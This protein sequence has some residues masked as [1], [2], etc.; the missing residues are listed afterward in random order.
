MTNT[1]RIQAHN[2]ELRECIELAENLP[3]AGGGEAVEPIIESLEVTENGTYTAPDG[4]DGYSPVSVNV[5]IPDGYIVPSGTKTITD[6]GEH[7][8][9]EYEKVEVSVSIP[10]GYIVPSG[11]L[12]V[13]ENGTY[14]V[15]EKA[16]VSVSVPTRGGGEVDTR[17]KDLAEGTLT[18]ID[19]NTIT[20]TRNYAFYAARSLERVS[21][22]NLTNLGSYTFNA[23]EALVSANLPSL[24][25]AFATY[26]FTSCSALTH[27][28]AP[29]ATGANNYSF[30]DTTAL[31][32]LDLLG[33]ATFGSYSFRRSGITA[34]II[35][36][37]TSK[38]A[39]LSSTNAFA[40]CPI[41]NGTGYIY[42]YRE[43]VEDYKAATGWSAYA[44][45]I[46]A[47]EDYPEICG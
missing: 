34:L 11:E 40:D 18:E 20:S 9:T 35:R 7:I 44:E 38:L 14:D 16:S 17:F 36:N 37:N 31:E 13:T 26:T 39:K 12:E 28:N 6:N 23:C 2:E 1:E 21:L 43:Y 25:G 45:Q 3:N 8:V 10:D 15:T 42:F 22:P 46:R 24:I 32:K 30:Q 29:N 27:V 19:D 4:V 33:T 47:I 5:P 41:A